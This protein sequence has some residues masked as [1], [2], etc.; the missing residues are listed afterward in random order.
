MKRQNKIA[1]KV[2]DAMGGAVKTVKS[3]T[4]KAKDRSQKAIKERPLTAV[5]AGVG[6]GV[7]VG[8]VA[9]AILSRRT[10]GKKK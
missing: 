10:K 7:A 5:A 9:A 6:A 2:G 1:S 3:G 4:G 8:A